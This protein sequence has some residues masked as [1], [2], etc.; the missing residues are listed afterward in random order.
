MARGFGPT[1][2]VGTTDR[3]TVSSNRPAKRTIAF[4]LKANDTSTGD[5]CV[6]CEWQQSN[7]DLAGAVYYNSLFMRIRGGPDASACGTWYVSHGFTDSETDFH[8]VVITIDGSTT[9][10]SAPVVRI[11]GVSKTV[12]EES[13]PSDADPAASTPH[14]LRLGNSYNSTKYI[15]ADLAEFLVCNDILSA[16]QITSYESGDVT[17]IAAFTS[18]VFWDRMKVDPPNSEVGNDATATGTAI[19][20]H[21]TMSDAPAGVLASVL[22]ANRRRTI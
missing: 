9:P 12:T 14:N 7:S 11:D 6:V 5:N 19:T 22:V 18:L 2:G 15:D 10:V 1:R 8:T 17:A 13:A 4:R 16:G 3:L 21:P 20:T